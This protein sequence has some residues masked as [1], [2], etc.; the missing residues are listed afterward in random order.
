MGQTGVPHP[1]RFYSLGSRF[2]VEWD[3]P[4]ATGRSF[5]T[6]TDLEAAVSGTET[7]RPALF[8]FHTA[9]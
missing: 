8:V 6:N 5:R 3:R 1:K 7:L 4:G 9:R 2:I